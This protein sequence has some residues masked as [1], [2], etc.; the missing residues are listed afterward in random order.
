MN[1]ALVLAIISIILSASSVII[2]LVKKSLFRP[3]IIVRYK[4][5]IHFKYDENGNIIKVKRSNDI[6]L[7]ED[8]YTITR[9]VLWNPFFILENKDLA[10]PVS[11]SFNDTIRSFRQVSRHD[12]TKTINLEFDQT[13]NV[14]RFIFD[15]LPEK[16]GVVFQIINKG[17]YATPIIEGRFFEDLPLSIISEEA[18]V[19][20]ITGIHTLLSYV[21]GLLVVLAVIFD[22]QDFM[23]Y[24]ILVNVLMLITNSF[25]EYRRFVP[26]RFRKVFKY[27]PAENPD[28]IEE[29]FLKDVYNNKKNNC[30]IQILKRK[31]KS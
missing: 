23:L 4:S 7:C 8:V 30:V 11:I 12:I 10:K 13:N 14:I 19:P 16:N 18:S 21:G 31:N 29:E 5:I 20:Q 2:P 3:T 27:T 15:Y 24:I 17:F 22:Y 26:K 25:D 6:T 1:A 28:A 9:F